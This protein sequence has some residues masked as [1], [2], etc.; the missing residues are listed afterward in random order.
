[1]SSIKSHPTSIEVQLPVI[2]LDQSRRHACLELAIEAA[3]QDVE[4]LSVSDVI[5]T[6]EAFERFIVGPA[7]IAKAVAGEWPPKP[8]PADAP[9]PKVEQP[10]ENDWRSR[11]PNAEIKASEDLC[12]SRESRALAFRFAILDSLLKSGPSDMHEQVKRSPSWGMAFRELARRYVITEV[13][14]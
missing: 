4:V 3:K 9:A 6:A 2:P 10:A 7:V 13:R 8:V 1:M 14:Q 12:E 11:I 5:R